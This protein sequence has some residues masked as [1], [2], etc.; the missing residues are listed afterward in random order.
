MPKPEKHNHQS[1]F[2]AKAAREAA[3]QK[4]GPIRRICQWIVDNQIS[5][6]LVTLIAIHAHDTF[7]SNRSSAFVHLQYKIPHD[8][9]GRY[10]RG[11]QD[12]YFIMYW[13]A[14]FTLVRALIMYKV[15][16]PF[17]RW[18]GVDTE[19]KVTRFAEQGWLTVYYIVSNTVGLYVMSEGPHWM[20]TAG[21]WINY[22]EGHAQMSFL[23]KS[24][25][26]VQMGFW[27]QQIFVLLV[28]EKRKDFVVM[29]IHHI[30]T[31]N[32]LGWSLYMNYTRIGNAVLCCMDFSDIFLTGTKCIR[33]LG[34]ERATVFSF[35]AFILSWVYTRHYLY[36]KILYSVIFESRVYLDDHMWNPSIGCY[37]SRPVIYAFA[38]LLSILQALI[39]YWFVL[40]LRIVYRV[41]FLNNLDD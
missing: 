41:I 37:Y 2:E 3:A 7:F 21:Y 6:S 9:L 27:F 35:A 25:Y 26:L 19:H 8:P 23:M 16:E 40:V 12:A 30:V 34:F 1:Y 15:L 20:N 5:G 4:A 32:L 13:V 17:A 11:S 39:I 31:C 33:Y 36:M 18:Y 22:P 29:G 10:Y 24:Y 14:A 28:E 38:V